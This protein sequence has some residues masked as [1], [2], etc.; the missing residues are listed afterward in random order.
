MQ[1]AAVG[2]PAARGALPV[3][4][5]PGVAGGPAALVVD[6]LAEAPCGMA[7]GAEGRLFYDSVMQRDYMVVMGVLV[8]GAVLTLVGNLL[9]DIMYAIVD[10]RLRR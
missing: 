5:A 10:P 8:M 9:A 1:R 3:E 6:G 4:D 7:Y 2:E